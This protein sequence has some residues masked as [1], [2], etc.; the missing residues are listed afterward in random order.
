MLWGAGGVAVEGLDCTFPACEGST[1]C[2][3]TQIWSPSHS[4]S[5]SHEAAVP[6]AA[7]GTAARTSAAAAAAAQ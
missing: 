3:L 4:M 5:L 6:A 2:L 7:A 1:H